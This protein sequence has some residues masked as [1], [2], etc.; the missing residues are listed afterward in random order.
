MTP[1][2]SAPSSP[3]SATATRAADA[4][5]P[6]RPSRRPTP[7]G[8]RA[9]ARAEPRTPRPPG[10]EPQAAPAPSRSTRGRVAAARRR[11]EPAAGCAR[12]AP[13]SRGGGDNRLLSP[14]VRRLVN[15]HG[16]DP[17]AITGT[18]PGGRITRDDVLDHIDAR[19]T[20]E[21]AAPPAAPAPAH[22]CRRLPPRPLAGSGRARG[23][24]AST[25]PPPRR[26]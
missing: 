9:A 1:S 3:S 24:G 12:A 11:P 20:P 14:V 21:A 17:D 2:T 8:D 22:R 23:A 4:G 25:A 7:A 19:A 26:W 10:A 15:E 5:R 6:D 18:G 16:L 13:S